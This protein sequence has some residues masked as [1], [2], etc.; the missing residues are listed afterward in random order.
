MYVIGVRVKKMGF[1]PYGRSSKEDNDKIRLKNLRLIIKN[2]PNELFSKTDI[3]YL[4][5]PSLENKRVIALIDKVIAEGLLK[6]VT[7]GI[8]TYYMRNN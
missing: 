1:N 6:M 7:K 4:I 8:N 2:S 3:R 5:S